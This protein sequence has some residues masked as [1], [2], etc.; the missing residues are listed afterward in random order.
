TKHKQ[1]DERLR[2]LAEAG[3][4]LDT[5]LDYETTLANVTAI[6]VPALADDCIIFLQSDLGKLEMVTSA[7]SDPARAGSARDFFRSYPSI[8]KSEQPLQVIH[9]T[10]Q[11]VLLPDATGEIEEPLAL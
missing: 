1:F 8:E 7:H 5:S 10:G 6:I 9:R 11:S 2:I 4:S 3:R